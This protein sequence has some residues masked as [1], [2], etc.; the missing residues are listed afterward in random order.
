MKD[1]PRQQLVNLARAMAKLE[2]AAKQSLGFVET[3]EYGGV[4]FDVS[5]QFV[6]ADMAPLTFFHLV[7]PIDEEGTN[8]AVSRLYDRLVPLLTCR[9][10]WTALKRA[11]DRHVLSAA[12]DWLVSGDRPHVCKA[13]TAYVLGGS[14]TSLPVIGR[15][16]K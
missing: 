4:S 5:R 13:C 8:A 16:S 14:K 9:H 15:T 6:I 3:V 12:K 11:S 1:D 7:E 10:E 2:K